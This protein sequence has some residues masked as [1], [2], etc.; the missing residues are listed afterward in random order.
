MNHRALKN[1]AKVFYLAKFAPSSTDGAL[2]KSLAARPISNR[3]PI[4]SGQK[5]PE[6]TAKLQHF[7][8][9]LCS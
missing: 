5:S 8:N 4:C 3:N 6:P 7:Y 9:T 2:G 1:D